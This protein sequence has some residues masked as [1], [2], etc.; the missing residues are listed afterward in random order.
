MLRTLV[1]NFLFGFARASK[2]QST[3]TSLHRMIF[4]MLIPSNDLFC[5]N[6]VEPESVFLLPV[7][8]DCVVHLLAFGVRP[9]LVVVRVLPS[10]ETTV[11]VVIRG[12]PPFLLTVSMV[13]S[14][15]FFILMVSAPG[16]PVAG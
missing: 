3:P 10:F 13:L 15:I 8:Y 5:R 7:V 16:I 12:F 2:S 6:L 1:Q 9:F 14:S 4:A 11:L